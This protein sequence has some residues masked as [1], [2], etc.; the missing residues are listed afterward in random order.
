[1]LTMF[2]LTHVNK[3]AKELVEEL[4]RVKVNGIARDDKPQQ[5]QKR[6]DRLIERAAHFEREHEL[7]VYKRAQLL[8]QVRKGLDAE[9]WNQNDVEALVRQL[10]T[11]RLKQSAGSTS[12]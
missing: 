12:R 11:H 7:N 3:F 5:I 2:D 9:R 10:M 6:I 8:S 4:N 1:M